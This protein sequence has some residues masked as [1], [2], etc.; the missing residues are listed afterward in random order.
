M[1]NITNIIW[2][3]PWS[4]ILLP[5]LLI[6]AYKWKTIE[7]TTSNCRRETPRVPYVFLYFEPE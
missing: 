4:P 1:S 7:N 6:G 3:N 5:L 2:K